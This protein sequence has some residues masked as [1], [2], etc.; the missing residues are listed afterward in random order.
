M[1]SMFVQKKMFSAYGS[2]TVKQKSRL[3]MTLLNSPG[4]ILHLSPFIELRAFIVL[5][6]LSKAKCIKLV[7]GEQLEVY[8][9]GGLAA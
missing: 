1:W 6:L 9:T 7:K 4:V 2:Y 5:L 3:F 8:S